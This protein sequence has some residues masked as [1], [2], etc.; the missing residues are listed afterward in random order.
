[1]IPMNDSEKVPC[2]FLPFR[3]SR[4]LVIY[5]HANAEDLG[6]CRSFCSLLRELFQVHILAVEYPGYGVCGGKTDE[7]GIHAHAEAALRFATQTLRWPLDGIKLFGRSLGTGPCLAMAA[8]YAVAGVILVSP[9][10]SIRDLFRAQV[11]PVAELVDDRFANLEV[12]KH[13]KSP[14][15][16]VHGQLDTLVPAKHGRA[17]YDA[18]GSRKMMVCPA[19]MGHNTS[20]LKNAG[21]LVL[22]MTQFFSLPDYAFEELQVPAWVY[23][24]S[25]ASSVT[26]AREETAAQE[27]PADGLS[28]EEIVSTAPIPKVGAVTWGRASARQPFPRAPAGAWGCTRPTALAEGADCSLVEWEATGTALSSGSDDA[29]SSTESKSTPSPPKDVYQASASPAADANV[30]TAPPDAAQESGAAP[31]PSATTRGSE[32]PQPT[33]PFWTKTEEPPALAAIACARRPGEQKQQPQPLPPPQP[34]PQPPQPP[35]QQPAEPAQPEALLVAACECSVGVDDLAVPKEDHELPE[36]PRHS[37]HALHALLGGISPCLPPPAASPIAA[38]AA[39][40]A[41][42]GDSP[43]TSRRPQCR[44]RSDAPRP[45][46]PGG[47]PG[48]SCTTGDV[49]ASTQFVRYRI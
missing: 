24:R 9:F 17:I 6:S 20:L 28:E 23:P 38:A 14:T 1:M 40:A 7:A 36:L 31:V 45:G 33:S 5:F 43:A 11:G 2:L 37:S 16:I 46:D 48:S 21:T 32:A 39:A 41:A 42:T 29:E 19:H 8:R 30:S 18:I 15:L 27:E 47:E 3:H 35:P 10:T 12:A 34:P 25:C 22:P 44:P 26:A 13:V 49:P 4:F